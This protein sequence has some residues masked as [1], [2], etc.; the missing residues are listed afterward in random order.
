MASIAK[1]VR[2]NRANYRGLRA[3]LKPNKAKEK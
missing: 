2:L 3:L 1:W